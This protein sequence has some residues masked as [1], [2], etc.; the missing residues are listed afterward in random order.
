MVK[1]RSG[2]EYGVP[3]AA[4]PFST[5]LQYSGLLLKA[6]AANDALNDRRDAAWE[7]GDGVAVPS[8][9]T[10]S[11][12]STAPSSPLLPPVSD[13]EDLGLNG[14]QEE[15]HSSPLSTPPSPP[16]LSLP[17]SLPPPPPSLPPRPST[18]NKRKR[19]EGS[20]AGRKRRR[21]ARRA[22]ERDKPAQWEN[23]PNHHGPSFAKKDP[24]LAIVCNDMNAAIDY[25]VTNGAYTV[26]SLDGL[27][28]QPWTFL[29]LQEHGFMQFNWDGATPYAILDRQGRIIAVLIGRPKEDD[30]REPEHRWPAAT[31]RVADLLE[32]TRSRGSF[33]ADN[34]PHR[35]GN[36][37]AWNVG[38]SYGTGQKIPAVRQHSAKDEELIET[39]LSDKDVQRIAHFQSQA[40]ASYF[41][42]VYANLHEAMRAL[43]KK[44]PELKQNFHG[45]IYP[46]VTFNLGPKTECIDHNDCGNA[47]DVPCTVTSLG[48]FNSD[49]GGDIYLWGLRLCIRFPAGSTLLLSSAGIRHGNTPIAEGERRYS[50][51]QYCAG[52]LLRWVRLGFRPAHVVSARERLRL[53]GTH[54]ERL[55]A[56]LGRLSRYAQLD[57]D[58]AWLLKWE[59]EQK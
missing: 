16:P 58:R 2:T 59:K 52:G 9:T 40:M 56:V 55:G 57:K 10:L 35:R 3:A 42:K 8:P 33:T 53:E 34:T 43:T 30:N 13:D 45:S 22:A 39:L 49:N 32:A 23:V 37:A 17:S 19:T 51:T 48:N 21:Q 4:A 26:K 7:S 25:L 14:T 44:Q 46:S 12:A 36:I 29:E 28:S 31:E 11:P 6:I 18:K 15:G 38:V 24:P 5:N 54:E 27:S 47:P 50:I 20:K 41:P 1:T